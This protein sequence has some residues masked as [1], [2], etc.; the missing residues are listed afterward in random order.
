[1]R[2]SLN[3]TGA[4]GSERWSARAS[5]PW[6]QMEGTRL[7]GGSR[8]CRESHWHGPLEQAKLFGPITSAFALFSTERKQLAKRSD[9]HV[10]Q[11]VYDRRGNDGEVNLADRRWRPVTGKGDECR[12][13][14]RNQ[15]EQTS[16]GRRP[17][18]RIASDA[19]QWRR[20]SGTGPTRSPS[21]PSR[22]LRR[23]LRPDGRSLGYRRNRGQF[24]NVA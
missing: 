7:R 12:I 13:G 17:S 20:A 4:W 2:M 18:K 15:P 21:R 19:R 14:S 24:S 1:M 3:V 8:F 16:K 5:G 9:A 10:V 23:R 6:K 11:G 22:L